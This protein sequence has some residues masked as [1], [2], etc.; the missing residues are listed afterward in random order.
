MGNLL[1][2]TRAD[3]CAAERVPDQ[4][5][6]EPRWNADAGAMLVASF[7]DP[8]A[9]GYA[10]VSGGPVEVADLTSGS[11][12]GVRNLTSVA[13][14]V[15]F[16]KDRM[17]A[18]D[19]QALDALVPLLRDTKFIAI[20][21]TFRI[22][23]GDEETAATEAQVHERLKHLPARVIVVRAGHILGPSWRFGFAFPLVPRRLRSCFVSVEELAAVVAA[24][25]QARRSRNVVTLLGPNRPWR[26]VLRE[27][28]T[29]CA[30]SACLTGV[31][32]VLSLL[33][34]GQLAALVLDLLRWR[35]PALGRWNVDT[36][37]PRSLAELLALC[38]RH[39]IGHVKVVGYNNGVVHFGHRYPGKTVVSTVLCNRIVRA[40]P[41][42]I[43]ADCGATI[44]DATEFLAAAGQELHVLP[45]YSYV[46]LGTAFFVPIHGSA[47]AYTTVAETIAKALLYDPARD[48]FVLATRDEPA[49]AEH[50]Y[51]MASRVI[52]L[53]LWI[54]V[55]PKSRYL[56]RQREVENATGAEL[57]KALRDPQASNVEIRKSKASSAKV[58]IS[59]Y[60]DARDDQ[61]PSP[62]GRGVGGEGAALEFPRDSLG[63]LWD[64]LEE[65]AITSFLMHALT[66]HLAWHVELFF[67]ADEFAVFW[68]THRD[69]P[70][71]KIQLRYIRRD[72]FPNSPFR[73]HDCVSVDLF[74]FRWGRRRF[75]KYLRRTFAIVRTNPGKHS[76]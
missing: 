52:V 17:T 59:T 16:M 62:S 65:N 24:E 4:R 75:E 76:Q 51:N 33:L 70:L 2:P 13:A 18:S 20:I 69:L 60:F 25:R 19:L 48:R 35:R 30:L 12:A 9:A 15:V 34:V 55:K 27:R 11:L 68:R 63:R 46:C 37:R 43:K 22:H 53:R 5:A 72:G 58:Q 66:R 57:V 44:R 64:R 54:R 29:P 32:F 42:V 67:P 56:V 38:H 40:G 41:E 3:E 14:C 71:K 45:N 6:D 8:A 36:L 28:R 26:D 39:N 1:L 49:F 61:L 74:M 10:R 23:L 50:V 47:A 73:D 31:C 7:G 21:S